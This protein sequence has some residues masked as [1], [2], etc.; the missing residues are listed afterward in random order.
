MS[1]AILLG[2]LE[3]DAE[4]GELR[5][6]A[7]ADPLIQE[8]ICRQQPDGSWSKQSIDDSA[9]STDAVVATALLLIRLGY[10]GLD[11]TVTKIRET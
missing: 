6:L 10:L 2:R 8:I 9:A 7:L 11:S 1:C 4:V 5:Q 3:D